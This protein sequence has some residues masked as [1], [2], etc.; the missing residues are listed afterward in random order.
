[1]LNV[2]INLYK[3]TFKKSSQQT[4]KLIFFKQNLKNI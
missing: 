3:F 2:F 4:K 1:M